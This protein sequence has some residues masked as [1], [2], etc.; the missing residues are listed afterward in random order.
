[1]I[2]RLA[3][4]RYH[5]NKSPT[6]SSSLEAI[7]DFGGIIVH[8]ADHSPAGMPEFALDENFETDRYYSPNENKYSGASSL[9]DLIENGIPADETQPYLDQIKF[10]NN[11]GDANEIIARLE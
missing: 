11:F 3:G 7:R 1:M 9:Q 4:S 2:A 8:E 10:S 5:Q 6:Q